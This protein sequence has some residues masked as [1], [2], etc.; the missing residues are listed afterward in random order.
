MS[1]A[2]LQERSGGLGEPGKPMGITVSG[3]PGIEATMKKVSA[4]KN[5]T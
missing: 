5:E 2:D 4:R 3:A 1:T